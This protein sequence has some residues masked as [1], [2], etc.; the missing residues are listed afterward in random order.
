[1]FQIANGSW[2][3]VTASATPNSEARKLNVPNVI[4]LSDTNSG[5]RVATAGSMSTARTAI[6]RN[7]RPR[8]FIR[9]NA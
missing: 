5:A 1:M 8:N 2:L 9:E 6:M 4:L 3:E 7:S